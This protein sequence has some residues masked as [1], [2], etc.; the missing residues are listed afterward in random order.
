MRGRRSSIAT[1]EVHGYELLYRANAASRGFDGTDADAATMQVL[2]NTLMSIGS[3]TVFREKKA[4][5]N[6]DQRLLRQEMYLTLPRDSIV[7]EILETVQ[8]TA[9]LIALCQGIAEQGY[10]LALDDFTDAPEWEPLTH[11]A[12][13]IKVDFRTSSREQQERMVST[14]KPRGILMLAEKVETHAEFEWARGAGYDLFQ[15]YFF[16][17]PALVHGRQIPAVKVICLRLSARDTAA[18][19]SRFPSRRE[20]LLREDVALTY[21]LLRYVNSALFSPAAGEVQSIRRAAHDFGRGRRPPMGGDGDAAD[22]GNRQADRTADAFAAAARVSASGSSKC[23]QPDG[24]PTQAFLMGMFSLLDALIDQPLDEALRSVDLGT[25]VTEALLGIAPEGSFL[26]QLHNLIQ[27][28]ERAEWDAVERL[29][30]GECGNS[31]SADRR[32]L[33]RFDGLGPERDP[34]VG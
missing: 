29:S 2:S 24:R 34:N 18:S 5:V 25:D 23:H 27:S 6:F 21:K 26:A 8:P 9:D 3:E 32:G 11:L 20:E 4:F 10:S 31:V 12:G 13:V 33:S 19:G 30:E 15:G 14:Y 1:E 17:R 7:I 22:A 28:Y 16:A